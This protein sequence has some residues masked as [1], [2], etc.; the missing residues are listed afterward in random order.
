MNQTGTFYYM[1]TRNHNFSN[2]DQKGIVYITPLLPPWAVGIVVTGSI[3]FAGAAAVAGMM[4]YS[5]S[6]PHSGIANLFSKI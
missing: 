1:N 2:R 4:F 6:H 3:L 5:K